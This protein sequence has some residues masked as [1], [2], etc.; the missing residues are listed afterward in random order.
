MA[1]GVRSFVE[2]QNMKDD[3]GTVSIGL[4]IFPLFEP[5]EATLS[6]AEQAV[7]EA[8]GAGTNCVRSYWSS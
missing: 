2:E 8:R 6:R 7:M 4:S 1:N 5:F 3:L